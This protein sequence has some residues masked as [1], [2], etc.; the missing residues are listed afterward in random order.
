MAIV[1]KTEEKTGIVINESYLRVES[2]HLCRSP[3][4]HQAIARVYKDQLAFKAG[5]P[6]FKDYP[7]SFE[8]NPIEA[9]EN[10]FKAAYLYL[11]TLPEF[12]DAVDIL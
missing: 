12:V 1:N 6:A 4:E 2:I 10:P 7:F 9:T 11:K 5:K 8:Y 3:L